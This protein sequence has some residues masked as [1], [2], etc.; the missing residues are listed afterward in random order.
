MRGMGNFKT[1]TKETGGNRNVVIRRMLR[2]SL[3]AKIS[4]ETVLQ[5]VDTIRSLTNRKC[6]RQATFF[7]HVMRREKPEDL[8]TTGMI[9]GKTM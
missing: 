8:V 6:K 5:E 7:G 9:E 2:I 4:D 3:T 1:R